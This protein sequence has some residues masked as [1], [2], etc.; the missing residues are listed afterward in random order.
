VQQGDSVEWF[1]AA[2]KGAADEEVLDG[3]R[4]VRAGRQWTVH[5]RAFRRYRS[6]LESSFDVVIDEIN[7]IPF[8]TSLWSAI[9]AVVFIHQLAREVWWYESPFPINA[10]GFACEPWY[11]RIYR[12]VPIVTVSSST[13]D[14]LKL[15]GLKGPI[16]V[17]PEGLEVT[18]EQHVDRPDTPRFLYVGRLAPSK[19]IADLLRALAAFNQHGVPGQ[20]RLIGD[21]APRYANRLRRLA[22]DLG[23][24]SNV[25]F[26]GRTS[27]PRKHQEMAS[28][29]M[30]LL[31]SVREGWGLVVTEAN[32][33]G[34]PAVAYDVPGL[35]DSIRPEETGLLV[36][37]TPQHLGAA[38]WRLWQD[39]TLLSR[40]SD[41]AMKWSSTFTFDETARRF[42]DA[43]SSVVASAGSE[44][45]AGVGA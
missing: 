1:S 20:L 16:T 21:G 29:H 15:L 44:R 9:P 36:P 11:L 22:S 18:T 19:R 43:V 3:V 2:F 26:L 33:Y 31:A 13:R 4:I 5:W 41:G 34:T 45:P 14:D 25:E 39:R 27:V 38:M 7:T 17:I 40:L 6:R 32:A 12:S 42:R 35:R 10:I 8:F 23:I 30:L 24:L 37:P 28:A